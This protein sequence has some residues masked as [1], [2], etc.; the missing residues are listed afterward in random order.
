MN[1]SSFPSS[2]GAA[3]SDGTSYPV[4]PPLPLDYIDVGNVDNETVTA[5]TLDGKPRAV[6]QEDYL[7][8]PR[9][10]NQGRFI[11][12][13]GYV[14]CPCGGRHKADD[15]SKSANDNYIR[16]AMT[17]NHH[18]YLRKIERER[19]SQRHEISKDDERIVGNQYLAAENAEAAKVQLGRVECECGGK[20]H[21]NDGS[22]AAKASWRNHCLTQQHQ[23]WLEKREQLMQHSST[24]VCAVAAASAP[25]STTVKKS[26]VSYRSTQAA[27]GRSIVN[28]ARQHT[29]EKNILN[30][31]E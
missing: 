30:S 17:K 15:G 5:V 29:K 2:G 20:H 9:F 25:T 6:E 22:A 18:K 14:D 23:T 10:D 7:R 26:P 13:R 24:F 1:F 4:I 28:A 3:T 16:H 11:G 31:L 19:R 8:L 12:K 27:S 21:R